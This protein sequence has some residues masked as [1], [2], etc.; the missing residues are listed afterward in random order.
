MDIYAGIAV[1]VKKMHKKKGAVELFAHCQ[2]GFCFGNIFFS[3][4]LPDSS[5]GKGSAMFP[6]SLPCCRLYWFFRWGRLSPA[7]SSMSPALS[8]CL[9]TGCQHPRSLLPLPGF[10]AVV[11]TVRLLSPSSSGISTIRSSSSGMI[12]SPSLS[13]SSIPQADFLMNH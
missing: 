8:G 11:S 1:Y 2:L 10:T 9:R 7:S 3:L 6:A 5:S 4:T 13:A 12:I